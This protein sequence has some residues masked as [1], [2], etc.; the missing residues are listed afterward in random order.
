MK[1]LTEQLSKGDSMKDLL[2]ELQERLER[3]MDSLKTAR[4]Q[5]HEMS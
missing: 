5:K 4:E 3:E 1:R 2:K